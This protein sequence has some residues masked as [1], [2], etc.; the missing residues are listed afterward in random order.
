MTETTLRVPAADQVDQRSLAYD[1]LQG[2]AD[3]THSFDPGVPVAIEV[4]PNGTSTI[5]PVGDVTLAQAS[6]LAAR[7]GLQEH[8]ESPGS[9]GVHHIWRGHR[10]LNVAVVFIDDEHCSCGKPVRS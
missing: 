10:T 4:R 3:L 6:Q 2:L 1:A 8:A 9:T 7:L 5:Q